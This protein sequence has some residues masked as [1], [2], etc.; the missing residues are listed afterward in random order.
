[1]L[2]HRGGLWYSWPHCVW[3][4]LQAT[5]FSMAVDKAVFVA[6][7]YIEQAFI[8]MDF[9]HITYSQCLTTS[10]TIH[11]QPEEFQPKMP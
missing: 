3:P 4:P 9:T 11:Y 7:N 5:D 2:Q 6:I 8:T 1:L 10:A